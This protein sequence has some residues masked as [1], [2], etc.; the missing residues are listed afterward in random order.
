MALYDKNGVAHYE[1][2]VIELEFGRSVQ[3]MSDIWGSEDRAIVWNDDKTTTETV[4]IKFDDMGVTYHYVS[5][6]VDATEE[7]LEKYRKLREEAFYQ[8]RARKIQSDAGVIN[9]GDIVKVVRGRSGVG[10]I[11]KIFWEGESKWGRKFG[12]ATSEV[13]VEKQLANGKVVM[14]NRDVVWTAASNVQKLHVDK[15]IEENMKD[16][17]EIAKDRAD[18]VIEQL[19]ISPYSKTFDYKSKAA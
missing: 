8:E 13:K 3:I 10:E 17:R 11:G 7:V 9:K 18:Q 5:G 15:I 4:C 19:K 12:I 1:G 14:G 6:E 2:R 16:C